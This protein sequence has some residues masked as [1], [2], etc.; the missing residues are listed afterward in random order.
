M[1]YLS[2]PAARRKEND[3]RGRPPSLTMMDKKQSEATHNKDTVLLPTSSK[4]KMIR[5]VAASRKRPIFA[6]ARTRTAIFSFA[7]NGVRIQVTVGQQQPFVYS[8]AVVARAASSAAS[9]S[10]GGVPPPPPPPPPKKLSLWYPVV[11]GLAIT[12]LGGAKYFHDHVGGTEGLRR[13]LSF[14]SL[15]IPKYLVYRYHQWADSPDHVWDE[16]DRETSRQG[17][18]KILELEGFY[19]KCGQ[20]CASNLGDAFPPIWQDTMSVLQDQCPPQPYE[21]IRDIVASELDWDAT[22]Q[23]FDPEPIGAASIGQV[24]RAVLKDGTRVVVKV[25]YPDVERLLRGDV[26]TIKMF[27]QVAQPVH[28]PGLEEM[29]KQFQ[30]E[31]DYRKEAQ[32]MADVRNNLTKAG[33]VGPGKLCQVPK[34]YMQ[35]CTKRVLVM[36]EL[37]GDKLVVE[38]DKDVVH[39]ASR[40]GQ[41]KKEYVES[42]KSKERELEQKGEKFKGPTKQEYDLFISLVD[43][44]RKARNVWNR[45]YNTTVGW[46]PGSKKRDYQ[47]KSVL[48]LNH[49]KLVDDLLEIHGHEVLV[50]GQFNGDPHP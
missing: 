15:A 6:V 28:V 37:A 45:L 10:T 7:R 1:I 33:L 19:I 25:C 17:L 48:P 20:L 12:V 34:P 44:K 18:N 11:G 3:D 50:D 9:S 35:Y 38:L 36:E 49:A 13:S 14:Y 24:H 40:A 30:T 29:E 2:R 8:Q 47:D 22:F 5:A 42:Q 46:M 16:L 27:A 41:T 39:H 32:N 26:R 23:S 31:F 21:T 4:R 43:G